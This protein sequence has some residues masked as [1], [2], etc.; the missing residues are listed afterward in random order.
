MNYL[1]NEDEKIAAVG[2]QYTDLGDYLVGKDINAVLDLYDPAGIAS[3][4][5]GFTGATL[6]SNKPVSAVFD[7]LN[8]GVY[9]PAK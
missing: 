4:V 8:R 9:K 2:K 6:R 1:K 3:D 5:D 7:A